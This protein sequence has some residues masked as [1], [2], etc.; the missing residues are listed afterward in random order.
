LDPATASCV[1][2]ECPARSS[3]PRR[4]EGRSKN[5]IRKKPLGGFRGGFGRPLFLRDDFVP[6][7]R[8]PSRRPRRA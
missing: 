8:R 6:V 1:V 7:S 3:R 2:R 4:R 5:R